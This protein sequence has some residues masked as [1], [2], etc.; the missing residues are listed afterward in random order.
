MCTKKKRKAEEHERFYLCLWLLA[1]A[2]WKFCAVAISI[3]ATWPFMQSHKRTH[4]QHTL[5]YIAFSKSLA[6]FLYRSCCYSR[7]LAFIYLPIVRFTVFKH[8]SI[9]FSLT[10]FDSF[11]VDSMQLQW[12]RAIRLI[13]T[14]QNSVTHVRTLCLSFGA[15]RFR[16][17]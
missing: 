5:S 9:H 7:I 10:L 14:S 3:E 6:I 17:F 13:F 1:F 16:M 15:V 2:I 11:A 4:T 8:V 12:K